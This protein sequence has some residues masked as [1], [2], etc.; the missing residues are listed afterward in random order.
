LALMSNISAPR[1]VEVIGVAGHVQ[2]QGLRAPGLPQIWM[3]Y[4]SKSYS[5]LD[6]V[7]RGENPA[8]FIGPVKEAAQRLGAGRPVHDVRLLREYVSAASADTRFA[9]FVLGAFAVL[10][11]ILSVIGVY[12]VVAYATARRTREI[13]VRL[14]LGADTSRIVSLVVRQGA[15]WI[16]AGLVAGL[17][18][19]RLLTGYVSGLLFAVRDTDLLTFASV[20]FGLTLVAF[21][22]TAMPALRASRIDPMLALKAE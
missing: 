8:S 19:A 9:L 15:V 13:A 12:A 21:V 5:G 2:S 20:A 7:I 1:W 11:L 18:G 4:G 16:T 10:A 17:I 6:I 14:A 22:A 3:T